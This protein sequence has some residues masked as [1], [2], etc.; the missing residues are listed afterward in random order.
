MSTF[1]LE[2]LNFFKFSSVVLDEFPLVLRHVFVHMWDNQVAPTPGFQKWDDSPLVRNMFLSKEGGK[3]KYVPT[4]KSYHEWDCTALFEATLYAQSFAMRDASG[5]FATLDKVY[6]KPRRLPSGT[7]HP[8]ISSP[9]GNQAETFALSLNQLRLLRNTLFHQTSTQKIDKTTF[10][11]YIQLAKDAF[12]A[13]GQDTTRIDEIGKLDEEDFPT[14]RLQKLEEELRREKDAAIKF[15]QISDHLVQIESQIKTVGSDVKTAAREVQLIVGEVA[16]DVKMTVAEVQNKLE[17]VV[18]DVK[19][20]VTDMQNKVEEVGSDVTTA[21]TDVEKKVEEVA[22]DV[23]TA[24]TDMQ[25]KVEKVGSDVTTAVTDVEKKVEEVASDVKTAVT[26][27]QNKVE[28]VG[29]DVTTA[30]THVEKKVEEVASDMITVARDVRTKVEEVRSDVEKEVTAV[31]TQVKNVGSDI[32]AK[33]EHVGLELAKVEANVDDVK[34][35]VQAGIAKGKSSNAFSIYTVAG[36]GEG[37]GGEGPL[38][39]EQIEAEGLKKKF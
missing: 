31:K 21:V 9:C 13:L 10:D 33:V 18:S 7:F 22:S 14:S 30:V 11:H 3:T 38:S 34:Q 19:T 23:K 32:I 24:V 28:E 1:A 27:M 2:Q 5:R 8:V 39:L 20:A 16:S 29:S 25:N 4:S 36:T 17:E 26:D 15:K 12:A 6:V 35:A 37:P